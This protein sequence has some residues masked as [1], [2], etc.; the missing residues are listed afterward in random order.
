MN[1]NS[2]CAL[3]ALGLLAPSA[4]ALAQD[5][6]DRWYFAPYVG[7]NYNDDDR[8]S[9]SSSILL[10]LG[11]GRYLAPNTSI[12]IFVD[13]VQREADERGRAL[14][15]STDAMD[16]TM[17]GVALRH[18]FGD[19]SWRPYVM[20]GLGMINHRDGVK[21]GWDPGATLGLGVQ[22]ALTD[23]VAFR[24][25]AA[26]RYDMDG[27]SIPTSDNYGDWNVTLG[28]TV[29]LG[30]APEAPPPAQP[31]AQ[32]PAPPPVDCKTLDDD[33]DGVNNCD[34]RCPDTAAG[35]IVGPDGCAQEV[36]IDLRGVEFLFDRPRP[37]QENS[38]DN[39]G[40]LPG[41]IEILEQAVDVL[42]RYPNIRVEVAGH[43][44]ST[45]SDEYNQKLSERRAQVV[46]AYLTSNGIDGS[47]LVGPNGYGESRPIDTNDTKEGRQRNRRTELGVQK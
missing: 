4:S 12:D 38:V 35:T 23:N 25:Q 45:G 33:K 26:Y 30:S 7:A 5:Y 28:L 14:F 32:P 2:L 9:E 15:R 8:L 27:D 16:S 43:T 47:R 22:R 1:R 10:G 13:R 17:F 31:P 42:K 37:G 40:L 44:D 19:G 36:V 11:V 24:A 20:G 34:D 46:Y 39:A 3:I 6:D 18:Y 41:S 29:A 21:T